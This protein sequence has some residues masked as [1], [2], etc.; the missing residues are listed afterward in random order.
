[1]PAHQA[2]REAECGRSRRTGMGAGNGAQRNS[3]KRSTRKMAGVTTREEAPVYAA[4]APQRGVAARK[5]VTEFIGTFFLTFAV[6]EAALSGS[7]FVPLAAGGTLMVMIYAG[8][9]IPGG[10]DQPAGGPAG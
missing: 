1:M 5:Y 6:G 8:G 4:P 2:G 7:V 3:R 10:H 9:G